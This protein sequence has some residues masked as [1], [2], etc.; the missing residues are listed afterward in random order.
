[1][2]QLDLFCAY[3]RA[4]DHKKRIVL[5]DRN[6]AGTGPLDSAVSEYG[7]LWLGRTRLVPATMPVFVRTNPPGNGML[8]PKVDG[9]VILGDHLAIT[10]NL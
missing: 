7:V 6:G 2:F 3:C 10:L 9:C 4:I 5:T 8:T 1:M